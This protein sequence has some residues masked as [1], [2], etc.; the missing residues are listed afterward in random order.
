MDAISVE[1]ATHKTRHPVGMHLSV[2]NATY[3]KHGIPLGMH[4]SVA[5][6]TYGKH[7]I[8]LGM[9]LSVANATSHRDASLDRKSVV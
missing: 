5:N 6:A 8:P 3:G 2:A 1:N 7:G 9:H 4:L